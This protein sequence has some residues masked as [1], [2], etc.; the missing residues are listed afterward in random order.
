MIKWRVTI[1]GCGISAGIP[2][3]G[4]RWGDC[5]PY[6]PKNRRKRASILI[7]ANHFKVLVDTSPDLHQQLLDAN[8]STIDAVVYTHAHADHLHGINDLCPISRVEKRLI[9]IYA[10]AKT[11]HSIQTAFSYALAAPSSAIPD[12]YQPFLAPHVITPPSSFI[13][14][15]LEVCCWVQDHGYSKSIGYRFGDIAYSTD[16]KSL[17]EEAFEKLKGVKIWI[18]DCLR[19]E[20][21]ATHSHLD[22][23]LEWITRVNPQKAILTHMGLEL[24][25]DSLKSELPSYIEPAYDGMTI[26]WPMANL[27]NVE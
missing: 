7:E 5:N 1:L 9:P 25:Y 4:N 24:D 10:D 14:E 3:V 13:I 26:D 6:N 22:Q 18:V 23:T 8:I 2:I 19:R 17:S 21:H 11:M 27:S 15:D 12:I 20:P 16:V